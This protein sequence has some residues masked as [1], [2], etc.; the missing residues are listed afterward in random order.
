MKISGDEIKGLRKVAPTSKQDCLKLFMKGNEKRQVAL[1]HPKTAA[2][3]MNMTSSRSHSI[4]CIYLS[5]PADPRRPPAKLYFVDL[6]G[7]ERN[8]RSKSVG[9]TFTEAKNIN[10]SLLTLEKVVLSFERLSE[11]D[12]AH[13][14]F[15]ESNL[16]LL[17]KELF[18]TDSILC[19]ICNISPEKLDQDET[20]N[21]LKFCSR[22]KNLK[23]K[24][25]HLPNRVA[26]SPVHSTKSAFAAISEPTV[27][28][29][30]YD[31]EISKLAAERDFFKQ[32][33]ENLKA[34]L[35]VT[36]TEV[37]VLRRRLKP[38]PEKDLTP[39]EILVYKQKVGF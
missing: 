36:K 31:E 29:R 33:T 8:A 27:D 15:R 19:I 35:E 18:I 37:E 25:T 22:C 7:S 21:T 23:I 6:A 10:L 3:S 20:L 5:D 12:K 1:F 38:E 4:F 34:E 32:T 30:I 14:P 9:K 2:T 28:K 24:L 13:F 17:L 39:N 16:T 26:N 11:G